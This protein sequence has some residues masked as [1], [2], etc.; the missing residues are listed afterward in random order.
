MAHPQLEKHGILHFTEVG[1]WPINYYLSSINCYVKYGPWLSIPASPPAARGDCRVLMSGLHPP[2][3][4]GCLRAA[5]GEGSRGA[6]RQFGAFFG[7][8]EKRS[9]SAFPE[10]SEHKVK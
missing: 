1:M 3:T 10:L 9:R 5:S 8:G 7:K 4:K 6:H 2:D